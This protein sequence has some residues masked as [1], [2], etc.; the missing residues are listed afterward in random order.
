[1]TPGG[2]ILLTDVHKQFPYA[3]EALPEVLRRKWDDPEFVRY[4]EEFPP[5]AREAPEALEEHVREL[6]ARDVKIAYLKNLQ[7]MRVQILLLTSL[8]IG[9]GGVR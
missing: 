5:G 1:M 6:T 8:P 3:I 7:G 9:W 2:D 4:R